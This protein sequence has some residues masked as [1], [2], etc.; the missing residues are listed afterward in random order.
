MILAAHGLFYE[1]LFHGYT[2][3]DDGIAIFAK[4]DFRGHIEAAKGNAQLVFHYLHKLWID[5]WTTI[6][7]NLETCGRGDTYMVE[8]GPH[9]TT[10]PEEGLRRKIIYAKGLPKLDIGDGLVKGEVG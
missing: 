5:L 2:I 6:P 10:I 7:G 8:N 9:Q 4:R 1:G 3:N